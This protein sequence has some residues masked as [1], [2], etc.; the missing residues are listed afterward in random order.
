MNQQFLLPPTYRPPPP[1]PTTYTS[2]RQPQWQRSGPVNGAQ[3]PHASN[4]LSN[5]EAR[6]KDRLQ[7]AGDAAALAVNALGQRSSPQSSYAAY[8]P[9]T[10]ST[11]YT[12]YYA[13]P[14]AA[15]YD[16]PLMQYGDLAYANYPATT[17]WPQQYQQSTFTSTPQ[18]SSTAPESSSN[19]GK[20]KK[21]TDGDEGPI[22]LKR[23]LETPEEIEKWREERRKNWPTEANI[24]KKKQEQ[25]ERLAARQEQQKRV[26]K[27]D[28]SQ[29]DNTL[30]AAPDDE[31]DSSDSLDSDSDMDPERDAISSKNPTAATKGPMSKPCKYFVKGNCRRGKRCTFR[32]DAEDRKN[33][34]MNATDKAADVPRSMRINNRPNLLQAL[35][36]KEI[37]NEHK[38][39]MQCF[40]WLSDQGY[41]D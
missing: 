35:L 38:I 5:L 20:R 17:T 34:K 14:A 27:Q 32:H 30:D 21:N 39:L 3:P 10:Y 8:Q 7:R 6:N 1:P 9:A 4:F 2:S 36:Q 31:P 15:S 24:A 26:K 28:G 41:L 18:V 22:R 19:V 37:N 33:Q 13:P 16:R 25:E 29:N 12:N 11:D 23:K 40:S